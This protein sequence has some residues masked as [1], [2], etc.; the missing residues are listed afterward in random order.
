MIYICPVGHNSPLG[1]NGQC[2]ECQR[3]VIEQLKAISL[4]DELRKLEANVRAEK[5]RAW[6]PE[7]L[8]YQEFFRE[9]EH[10]M[11]EWFRS[12]TSVIIDALQ[13]PNA[14]RR[15]VLL[16]VS[17]AARAKAVEHRQSEQARAWNDPLRIVHRHRAE[18][19]ER[20]GEEIGRMY[21][22]VG[23]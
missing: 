10:T 14:I 9:S 1:R 17:E 22:E 8:V 5:A 6:R 23:L 19:L 21:R 13:D 4:A 20:F 11:I 12:H 18:A 3:L 7:D 16:E 15:K 2:L